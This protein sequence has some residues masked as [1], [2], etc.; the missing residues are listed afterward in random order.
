[1]GKPFNQQKLLGY[2]HVCAPE[3]LVYKSPKLERMEMPTT[4]SSADRRSCTLD[5]GMLTYIPVDRGSRQLQHRCCE[6]WSLGQRKGFQERTG[7]DFLQG[8]LTRKQNQQTLCGASAAGEGTA[9]AGSVLIRQQLL[10]GWSRAPS[11]SASPR[12]SSRLF[13][14]PGDNSMGGPCNT[15]FN[16]V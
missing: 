4:T 3:S 5:R 14:Q 11:R 7:A 2:S 6:G 8:K 15:V 16:Y 1:M 12:H 13:L 10:P 9:R